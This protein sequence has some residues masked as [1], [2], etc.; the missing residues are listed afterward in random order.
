MYL[1]SFLFLIAEAVCQ[2]LT[3]PFCCHDF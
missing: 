2:T 3:F 1:I